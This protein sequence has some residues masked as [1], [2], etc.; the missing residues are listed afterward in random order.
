MLRPPTITIHHIVYLTL[1]LFIFDM[2][3]YL[4]IM[5]KF[6]KTIHI[7]EKH[8]RG[9]Y[10]NSKKKE[11]TRRKQSSFKEKTALKTNI[12]KIKI[13]LILTYWVKNECQ[14]S[15]YKAGNKKYPSQSSQ[16]R[17]QTNEEAVARSKF[18]IGS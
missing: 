2:I 16:E 6:F 10:K 13:I 5:C 14:K 3:K 8:F 9:Y 15:T 11:L 18:T 7:L 1:I 12:K 4:Y 17:L